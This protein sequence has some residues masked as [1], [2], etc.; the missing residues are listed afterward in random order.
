MAAWA[1]AFFTTLGMHRA[2][3]RYRRPLGK[4]VVV[5]VPGFG[6]TVSVADPD[7][8]KQVFTA[9][10]DVLHG[11]ESPLR[12]VLGQQSSF[13]LDGD[14]H[15]RARRLLLPP[16]HGDRVEAYG[17]LFEDETLRA[18]ES[19]P[20]GAEFA[21]I[22]ST[23][24][25]T[26]NV[27]IRAVF[28]AEDHDFDELRAMLPPWV[29]LGSLLVMAPWIHKDLGRFSPW[30]RFVRY[31]RQFD[32]IVD[33]LIAK[34][35]ADPHLAERTDILAMLLQSK[36]DDGSPMSRD[37]IADQLLTL[38]VAGHETTA[39]TLSWAIERI[40][41]HPLLLEDLTREARSGGTELLAATITEVQRTRPVIVG[42]VRFV[43]KPFQL[44]DWLLRPGTVV[45][46]DALTMHHDP[47]LFPDPQR[48][49]PRRFIGQTPGTYS[50]IPFGGGR[51]RCVGAAFAQQE[52]QSVL[53]TILRCCDLVATSGKAERPR[54]RGVAFH[55]N[56]GGRVLIA[57]INS[58]RP[59]V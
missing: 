3:V 5:R 38:L 11:G 13:G 7:L 22:D 53:G 24:E 41:R 59:A 10:A 40:R 50:W 51:R 55:P 52:M 33:N 58:D 56:R 19:W 12:H 17:Q 34:S 26:I 57:G 4:A 1:L 28:G 48:F 54:Y 29:E 2:F 37:Q 20:I 46:V 30:G 14:E 47:A 32:S 27:I 31:R 21:T 49:E 43:K 42:A 15:L 23:K 25:I 45:T 8:A 9:P 16:F 18:I 6:D 39:A 36:Y 44:G 35:L